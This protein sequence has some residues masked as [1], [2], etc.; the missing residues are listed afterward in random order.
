MTRCRVCSKGRIAIALDFGPQPVSNRF[1]KTRDEKEDLF[2]LSQGIC[3]SCGVVQLLNGP[4]SKETTPRF[5]WLTQNE[6]EGHLDRVVEIIGTLPGVTAASTICGISFKDDSTLRRINDRGYPKTW[7]L[8]L[9]QDFKVTEPFAGIETIQ[10]I[11]TEEAAKKITAKTGRFDVLIVRHILE[12][13]ENIA[14]FFAA[15]KALVSD[16]GHIVFEVPDEERGLA[17]GDYSLVWEEHMVYFTPDTLRGA[18]VAWGFEVEVFH[19]FPYAHENSL[20]AIVRKGK[21]GVSAVSIR[22]ETDRFAAYANSFEDRRKAIQIFLAKAARE[23]GGVAMRGAGHLTSAF[24]NL[25]GLRSMV[26]F[27]VDDNPNKQGLLMPGSKVPIVSFDALKAKKVG[28]CLLGINPENE[29]K[30][31]AKNRAFVDEGGT[32]RSIFPES[33]IALEPLGSHENKTR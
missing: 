22:K 1:L 8:S 24:I 16:D 12:H 3:D 10:S 2:E 7:R 32:F 28:L 23:K 26:H 30:V 9:L 18:L 5:E 20:I 15:L 11:L 19:S 14:G 25:H 31:L 33:R 27:V 13:A 6:P 29:E 17:L 4:S 21:A